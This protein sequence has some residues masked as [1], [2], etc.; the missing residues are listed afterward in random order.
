MLMQDRTTF[1]LVRSLADV[2]RAC[3]E[4]GG[5]LSVRHQRCPAAA[6]VLLGIWVDERPM[7]GLPAVLALDEPA[8]VGARSARIVEATGVSGV[9]M[10]YTLE[11]PPPAVSRADLLAA[12]VHARADEHGDMM[13]GRFI[14][15]FAR[16][17]APYSV[18][19]AVRRLERHYPGRLL[20]PLCQ[21]SLGEAQK[22]PLA[23][24]FFE[25]RAARVAMH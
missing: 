13:R 4:L 19:A 10:M 23:P 7:A 5:L 3:R 12:L 25:P 21:D 17:A 1:A 16:C 9:W 11:A 20:A 6:T 14:P 24:L 2:E 18:K 22:P 8:A 15:V